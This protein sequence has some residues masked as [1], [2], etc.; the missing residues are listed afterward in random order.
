MGACCLN[1]SK[2]GTGRVKSN[3]INGKDTEF[4]GHLRTLADSWFSGIYFHFH[5]K[6]DYSQFPNIRGGDIPIIF[7]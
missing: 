5:A 7:F 4:F 2:S 1:G 3:P 6:I